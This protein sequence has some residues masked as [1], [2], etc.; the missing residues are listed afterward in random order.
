MERILFLILLV[1]ILVG[2]VFLQIFLSKRE[3]KWTGL[4]LPFITFCIAILAVISI[5]MFVTHTTETQTIN[6]NGEV[7]TEI[8]ESTPKEV[9]GGTSSIIFQIIYIFI[10]YNIPTAILLAIYAA[11]RDKMKKKS[12]IEKMNIIDLE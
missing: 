11:C 12:Q 1:G 6:E 5:P 10:I 2:I 9:M 8:I 3:N 7:I 4:V